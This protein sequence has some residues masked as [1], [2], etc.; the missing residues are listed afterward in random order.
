MAKS[1]VLKLFRTWPKSEFGENLAA[2]FVFIAVYLFLKYLRYTKVGRSHFFR[3]RLHS[4]SKMF[5]SGSW[6]FQIWESDYCSD[7]AYHR[8]NRNLPMLFL[9]NGHP[10]SCYCRNWEVTPALGGVLHKILTPGADLGPKKYRILPESTP[11][12]R[13]H[14]HLCATSTGR[15]RHAVEIYNSDLDGLGATH[16]WPFA[17]LVWFFTYPLWTTG[18]D[19]L[20][21]VVLSVAT[22]TS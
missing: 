7:S 15:H 16:F 11:A 13:I 17:T 22:H 18:S 3:L 8:S 10:D 21:T 4:C 12:L 20:R 19:K 1:A 2:K 5:E 6:I 9:R 14:G